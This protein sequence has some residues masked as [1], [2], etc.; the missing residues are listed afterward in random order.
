MM[1]AQGAHDALA[2]VLFWL[3][4]YR[5]GSLAAWREVDASHLVEQIEG[6]QRFINEG[7]TKA[8]A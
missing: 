6:V 5:A 3:K 7:R 2:D 8:D 4:G 1:T